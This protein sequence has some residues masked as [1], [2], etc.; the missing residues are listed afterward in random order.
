MGSRRSGVPKG[1]ERWYTCDHSR[2]AHPL[3]KLVSREIEFVW[4]KEEAK[5]FDNN[6]HAISTETLMRHPDPLNP[7]TIDREISHMVCGV[8]SC[9]L[10]TNMS[11]AKSTLWV[12]LAEH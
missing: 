1:D 5:A 9:V 7:V 8:G 2:L 4:G 3:Q 6:E 10:L 11:L 12:L